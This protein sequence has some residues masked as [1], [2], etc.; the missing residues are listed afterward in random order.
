MCH[1]RRSRGL[2]RELGVHVRDA[3]SAGHDMAQ[4][5]AVSLRAPRLLEQALRDDTWRPVEGNQV[6]P[7]AQTLPRSTCRTHASVPHSFAAVIAKARCCEA[8]V[9]CIGLSSPPSADGDLSWQLCQGR[10]RSPPQLQH[11]TCGFGA[12]RCHAPTSS[13][14]HCS[15]TGLEADRCCELA[16]PQPQR[17]IAGMCTETLQ[18]CH[19]GRST[20]RRT[21]LPGTTPPCAGRAPCFGSIWPSARAATWAS[22]PS[23][24]SSPRS[25]RRTPIAEWRLRPVVTSL[26]TAGNSPR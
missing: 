1:C 19:A 25:A 24:P 12:G 11:S 10:G 3:V 18:H 26:A 9:P 21:S 13:G 22:T 15:T 2:R 16:L 8:A 14:C 6:R 5:C 20:S 17:C 7:F 4:Q 23:T